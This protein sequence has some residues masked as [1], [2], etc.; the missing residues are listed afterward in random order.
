MNTRQLCAVLTLAVGFLAMA[1]VTDTW[2]EGVQRARAGAISCGGNYAVNS[3]GVVTQTA[4]WTLRNRNDATALTITHLRIFDALGAVIYDSSDSGLPDSTNGVLSPNNSVLGPH[5]STQFSTDQLLNAGALT[6]LP[7][8]RRPIEF[9]VDWSA[10]RPVAIPLT[11]G[12]TRISRSGTTGEELSRT[13]FSCHNLG[14][15]GA[16]H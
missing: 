4:I 14:M 5:Q 6:P 7:R 1:S 8:T 13:G 12:L 16:R 10:N 15:D 3:S 9:V 2:A 11:G